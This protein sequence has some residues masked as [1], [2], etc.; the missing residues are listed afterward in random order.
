MK[1]VLL[2]SALLFIAAG[3]YAGRIFDE[4]ANR[5]L[6]IMQLDE[7]DASST[8]FSNLSS[9]SYYIPSMKKLKS[10]AAGERAAQVEV[11]GNYVKN[12]LTSEDFNKRFNRYRESK[13]PAV[14]EKPKTMEQLNAENKQSIKKSIEEMKKAKTSL[15]ADQKNI[16]DESIKM[17]EEQLKELE[18]PDNSA[19]N[20]EMDDYMKQ[21]YEQQM[22]QHKK[23]VAEWEA[24][25]PVGKPDF[26]VKTWLNSFLEV[27]KD[28]DFKAQTAIDEKGRT[29]FVKQEYERKNNTWKLC[30]RAGKET[31]EA[32]RKFAQA[33]LSE[34][35]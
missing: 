25:Y 28:V 21:A 3:F 29:L 11:I 2:I 22:E 4:R 18:N 10:I 9:G 8:I 12:Y 32:A 15:P 20:A 27:S 14:P 19:Y 6:Q 13:K 1:K 31:T 34:L 16:Y 26:L 23:D 24:K 33:W 7:N 35:K 17:M 5:L 30:F